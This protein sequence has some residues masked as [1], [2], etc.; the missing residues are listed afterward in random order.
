MVRIRRLV[1]EFTPTLVILDPVSSLSRGGST[2]DVS[3]MLVRQIYYLKM[4]GVTAVMTVLHGEGGLEQYNQN[5]S[6]L[7]DTW[8]HVISMDARGELNRGLYL[9]KSR[10]MAHSNQIREFVLSDE[11]VSPVPVVIGPDGVL[12]GS[13]RIA[14][15][16]AERAAEL[17]LSQEST[18]LASDLERRRASF[19]A[20]MAAM[21]AEF[22]VDEAQAKR[23]IERSERAAGAARLN[24]REQGRRR[25]GKPEPTGS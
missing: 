4:D 12:T 22:E 5:I 16:S 21:Q 1:A 7:V 19:E 25:S 13:A 14:A 3:A 8:V 2:F 17:G 10:G 18:D 20:K 11:G 23:L 9:L 24:R 15:D 6:S